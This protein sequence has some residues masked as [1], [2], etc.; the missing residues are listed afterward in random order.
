MNRRGS[1]SQS[2][3]EA[4]LR[5]A[6]V[7]RPVPSAVRARVLAR[8]RSTVGATATVLPQLAFTPSPRRGLAF[9]LVGAAAFA[10][11]VAAAVVALRDR[12]PHIQGALAPALPHTANSALPPPEPPSV[13]PTVAPATPTAPTSVEHSPHPARALP[14]ESYAAELHLLHRAQGA[15]ASGDFTAA[16]VVLAEHARRFPNGRLA[17]EREALRV[18]SLSGSGRIREAHSAAEAFAARFPRSVL[19]P[20]TTTLQA[21]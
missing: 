6:R 11:G 1:A 15:Y 12:S 19:L 3:L 4:L 20:R 21:Q 13:E 18:R 7:I 17:E 8:A 10:V 16:L 2:E 9:A 14:Q 5:Q